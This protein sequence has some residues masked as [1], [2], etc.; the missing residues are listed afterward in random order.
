MIA[1]LKRAP[2]ELLIGILIAFALPADAM[3]LLS[4]QGVDLS[5][6]GYVSG[7]NVRT[8]GVRVR[9]VCHI[10]GGWSISVD[11]D[12]TPSGRLSGRAGQGVTYLDA[13]HLSHL[14]QLFLIEDLAYV[15]DG[16]RG[17]EPPTFDG[18]V[19][20]GVYGSDGANTWQR[21]KSSNYALAPASRCPELE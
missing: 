11:S 15:L 3:Q 13:T 19:R 20:V 9:A 1:P 5:P 2:I 21:L 12:A 14:R 8:W 16:R 4:I 17:A 10:P 6:S 7:F 18:R